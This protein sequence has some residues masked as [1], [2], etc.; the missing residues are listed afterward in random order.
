MRIDE[1]EMMAA[2]IRLA[3]REDV[4]DGDHTTLSCIPASATDKAV[5]VAKEAG[6]IAGMEVARMVYGQMDASIV[7]TPLVQDGCEVK[8]GDRIFT[9]EGASR[10]ILTAERLSLNYIQRMSGIA[11]YTRKLTRL[12]GSGT[13]VLLDTRKTT[14]NNRVFEKMAV[15]IGGGKNHRFG[16]FD[17]IL[18]K[19]NHIDF[20]G[21]IR[22]AIDAVHAYL[23]EKDLKLAVEIEVRSFEEL[24]EV[25]DRG[26]VDRIMLDNFTPEDIRKAVDRI[27]GRFETEASGGINEQTLARYAATGVDF[28]SVGA[29]THHISSLDL[30]LK[31]MR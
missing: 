9:V 28:I 10:S 21:G 17:M 20:A 12:V 24:D 29:L 13:A 4:G 18:V 15:R 25:L 3:L 26:G 27:G 30:S 22:Q 6:V 19:D 31:A 5:L 16:L 7:F 23:Q 1:K 8:P 14:P 2:Y 11:T